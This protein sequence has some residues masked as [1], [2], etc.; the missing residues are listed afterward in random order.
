[1]LAAI[2]VIADNQSQEVEGIIDSGPS[3]VQLMLR[4]LRNLTR[5][6]FFRGFRSVRKVILFVRKN[7]A[8]LPLNWF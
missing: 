7:A 3:T 2:A 1:L 6:G 5:L 8:N 4:F